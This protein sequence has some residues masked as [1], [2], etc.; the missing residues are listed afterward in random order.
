L[1]VP[2]SQSLLHTEL[3]LQLVVQAS[4]HAVRVQVAL[5][6][7]S[8]SQPLP[9]QDAAIVAALPW[10][11]QLPPAQSNVHSALPE[12]VNSQPPVGHW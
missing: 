1:Q 9:A 3:V 2:A 12:Q 4:V 8:V 11:V 5:C 7:Q 10:N 6:S